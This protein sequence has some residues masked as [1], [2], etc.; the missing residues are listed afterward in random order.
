MPFWTNPFTRNDRAEFLGVVV[1]LSQATRS[2]PTTVEASVEKDAIQK[3]DSDSPNEP[4]DENHDKLDRIGS[5]EIGAASNPEFS[6][7]TI[8]SLRAEVETGLATS[9]H[10]STYDR[11]SHLLCLS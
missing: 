3:Q 5:E 8:E 6:H 1:P 9:G 10:D 7:L 2:V 4:K 11:M